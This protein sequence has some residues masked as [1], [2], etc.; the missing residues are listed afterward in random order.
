MLNEVCCK[1]RVL[2]TP[3]EELWPGVS[4][5]PDYKSTFPQWN[6]SS[7][8]QSVPKLD[9]DGLDIL[10]VKFCLFSITTELN[11]LFFFTENAH[12]LPFEPNVS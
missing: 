6:S 8:A 7:L 1:L 11:F 12:L 3:N 10:D 4:E 5:L 9:K 2:R